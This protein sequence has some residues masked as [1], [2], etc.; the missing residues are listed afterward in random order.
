MLPV[1]I[2]GLGKLRFAWVLLIAGAH[3]LYG[4]AEA[5]PHE[6]KDYYF[7]PRPIRLLI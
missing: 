6:T 3:H 1:S 7:I 2:L 4:I 5:A